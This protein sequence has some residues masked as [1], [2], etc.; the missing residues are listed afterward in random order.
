MKIQFKTI[1]PNTIKVED[2]DLFV[3]AVG[4]ES[5]STYSLQKLRR[6]GLS[7]SK[8]LI[9]AFQDCDTDECARNNFLSIGIASDSCQKVP[10][11]DSSIGT[12]KFESEVLRLQSEKIDKGITILVDYSS[13]PRS[14]YC[15][16]LEKVFSLRRRDD[17]F[18]FS[19][20]HGDYSG[21]QQAQT[22]GIDRIGLYSGTPLLDS[23]GVR[24]HVIGLGYDSE[25]SKAL[26]SF[27]D[28]QNLFVCFSYPKGN[29]TLRQNLYEI[30]DDVLQAASHITHLYVDDFESM[31]AKLTEI[32][33]DLRKAGT[34]ILV[35]D[36]PKPAILAFSILPLIIQANGVTCLKI[37]R[38]ETAYHR[39]NVIPDKRISGFLVEQF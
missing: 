37:Y 29:E 14:L 36:G 22:A 3:C 9:F 2:I 24:S 33:L 15:K 8:L 21:T 28:P 23:A 10:Y 39:A 7:D 13:M 4:Y 5:R 26:Y 17:V 34:V 6:A 18:C 27:L 38:H 32:V 20:S 25:R 16:L 12:N 31:I 35:P 11:S 1:D 30:N 19:Y